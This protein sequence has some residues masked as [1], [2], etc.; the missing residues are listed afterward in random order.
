MRHAGKG[1]LAWQTSVQ[2]LCSAIISR[3]TPCFFLILQGN[4]WRKDIIIVSSLGVICV[5]YVTLTG[6]I[7]SLS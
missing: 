1:D 5:N 7:F 6:E 3:G 2:I 4:Y